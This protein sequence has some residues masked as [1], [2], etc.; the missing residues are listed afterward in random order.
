MCCNVTKAFC[1]DLSYI[2]AFSFLFDSNEIASFNNC[3][4]NGLI[5]IPSGGVYINVL[6]L[7]CRTEQLFIVVRL[8]PL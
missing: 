4:P 1:V 7:L 8:S 5:F 2:G 6:Y 3:E